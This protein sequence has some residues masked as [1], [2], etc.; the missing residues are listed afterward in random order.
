MCGLQVAVI[1][2]CYNSSN[3]IRKAIESVLNQDYNEMEIITID[4]GSTDNTKD[5]LK[6]YLPKIKII[7]HE[8]GANLGQYPSLNLGIE[9]TKADLI[10]FLDHDDL[11][12]QEKIRKQVEI[13]YKNPAIGL[14]YSNGHAIDE[15]DNVLYKYFPDQFQEKNTPGTILLDC[16]IQTPSGVMVKREVLEKVGL[17][18][19]YLPSCADHDLWVR[20][21]EVTRFYYIPECL[22]AYRK[23]SRQL[24]V[25][26]KRRM[27]QDGLVVL[28]EA[29]KRYPYGADL[30]RKRLAVL[31][32]RLG[33]CDWAEERYLRGL[34]NY[35]MA[36]MFDPLRGI[37]YLCSN[38][39]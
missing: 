6:E 38:R 3:Y 19:T 28:K 32:Y 24:S 27:W 26:T 33:E 21:S 10:A 2:P 30:K 8:N 14:V 37:K 20:M 18:K 7:G 25:I 4:D 17:F 16:Y 22:F 12:Y 34:K 9:S 29:F 39:R 31:Y 11:W 35:L 1:I 36:G 5:I 13:I 23:H 15:N